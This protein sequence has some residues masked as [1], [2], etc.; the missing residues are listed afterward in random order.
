MKRTLEIVSRKKFVLK[1]AYNASSSAQIK[2]SVDT[3]DWRVQ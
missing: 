1:I 3:G 2:N